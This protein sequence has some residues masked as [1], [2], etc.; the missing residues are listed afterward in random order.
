MKR[1]SQMKNLKQKQFRLMGRRQ[2]RVDDGGDGHGHHGVGQH[3]DRLGVL[4][5]GHG[6]CRLS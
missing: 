5:D 6:P 1:R 3:V 4:V 2:A